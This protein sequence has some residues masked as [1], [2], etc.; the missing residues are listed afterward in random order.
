MKTFKDNQGQTWTINL[1]IPKTMAC[2]NAIGLDLL[3]P[4]HYLQILSSL[5]D[6]MTFV[7]LLCEQEAKSLG[8]SVDDFEQ[9]LH[10]D[11]IT[12]E[13]SRAFLEE[14]EPF[15]RKFGQT[16]KAETTKTILAN[17][18]FNEALA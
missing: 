9:R 18:N 17:A 2:I 8:V 15:F 7:F 13:A 5:T 4:Q 11:G 3:N 6:R 16:Q 14:C 12:A 10:G 1:T